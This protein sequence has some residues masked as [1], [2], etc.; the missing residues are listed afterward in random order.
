MVHKFSERIGNFAV[1]DPRLAVQIK[2]HGHHVRGFFANLIMLGEKNSAALLF[3]LLQEIKNAS[4]S[5]TEIQLPS[6]P[7][8]RNC[9]NSASLLAARSQSLLSVSLQS[10][11]IRESIKASE[12]RLPEEIQYVCQ[13]QTKETCIG[14]CDAQVVDDH[15]FTDQARSALGRSTSH[16]T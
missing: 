1:I 4:R 6:A 9:L 13:W 15:Q 2:S 8:W 11:T 10:T 7:L 14:R 5:D 12:R 3:K 16:I